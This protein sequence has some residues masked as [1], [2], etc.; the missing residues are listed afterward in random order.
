MGCKAE[1]QHTNEHKVGKIVPKEETTKL[2]IRKA[3]V[4]K[5]LKVIIL[6]KSTKT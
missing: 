4:G 6:E 1:Q 3:G 2:K 5:Y